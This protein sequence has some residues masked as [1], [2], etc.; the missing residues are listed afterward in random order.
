MEESEGSAVLPRAGGGGGGSSSAKSRNSLLARVFGA[1]AVQLLVTCAIAAFIYGVTPVRT[2]IEEHIWTTIVG[3]VAFFVAMIALHFLADKRPWNIVLVCALTVALGWVVGTVASHYAVP[4][5]LIAMSLTIA[6]FTALSVVAIVSKRDF[7][8][9]GGIIGVAALCLFPLIM[10][11]ILTQWPWVRTLYCTI[12]VVLFSCMI[13]F[14]VS[15]LK[16]TY[17]QPGEW[18]VAACHIYVEAVQIFLA[19]LIGMRGH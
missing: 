17:T 10:I 9:L 12:A 5:L 14:N 18:L 1:V 11:M 7:S 3:Y 8:F 4:V 6:L 13:L 15:R 2:Y 16:N 19:L